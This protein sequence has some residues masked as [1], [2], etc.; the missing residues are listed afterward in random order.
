MAKHLQQHPL[1]LPFAL[2]L[3]L[4]CMVKVCKTSGIYTI[5]F[6]FVSHNDGIDSCEASIHRSG[7]YTLW[8]TDDEKINKYIF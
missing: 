3:L 2:C 4:I 8:R 7:T 1:S 6:K 5:S